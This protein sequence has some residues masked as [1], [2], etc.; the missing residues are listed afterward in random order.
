MTLNLNR[1]KTWMTVVL[2]VAD[3]RMKLIYCIAGVYRPAGMERVL[4]NKTKALVG[5]GYDVV[6]ITTEQKGRRDAFEFDPSIRFID[7]G[8]GYEDNNGGSFINKL[9]HYPAK[10]RLHR[11]K[12]TD[13]LT[14]EKADI[15]V[16]MFCGEETFLPKIKDGSKKVLEIHFSRFKRM[17]YGRKGL[18]AIADR[19]RSRRDLRNVKRFDKFVVLTKEDRG[20]WGDLDNIVVIPNARTFSFDIPAVLDTKTVVALGRFS[21]QKGF[22]S[23]IEAWRILCEKEGEN[24]DGWRLRIIG[25]GEARPR[26]QGMVDQYGLSE[27]VSLEGPSRDVKAEY[28]MASIVASPSRYDGLPMVL[29]ES[30]AAGVPSVAF[31]CKC[32]PRDIIEDGRNGFLVPEGDVDGFADALLRLMKD[33]VL[34]R[35]MGSAAFAMSDDWSEEKIMKQ[36][37]VLFE[38]L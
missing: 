12:L 34:L 25:D 37:E 3:N 11:K 4:A 8:I 1:K 27:T 7:L 16:S 17:Q 35:T 36:W 22:D 9:I 19:I 6:I 10:Q 29:L 23:L 20:Y 32:G 2:R 31:A 38:S 33:P 5:M 26:L 30:Q 14:R 28:S 15:V 21:V 13:I 24:A 18:W